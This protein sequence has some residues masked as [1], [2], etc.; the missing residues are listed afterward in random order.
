MS[1]T[2]VLHPAAED[3]QQKH[4]LAPRLA[5]LQGTTIGLIDNHKKN[6]DLY[7][8]EVSRVLKTKYGVAEIIHYRK[9]SQ[10]MPTPSAVMDDLAKR[11]DAIVHGIAD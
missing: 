11:C 7:L 2:A 1:A 5:S 8:D 10:S 9:D 4:T 3:I 6:A